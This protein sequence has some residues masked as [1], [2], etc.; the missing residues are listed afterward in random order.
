[1]FRNFRISSKSR[2]SKKKVLYVFV[3]RAAS[4]IMKNYI[5][6]YIKKSK[7]KNIKGPT[8]EKRK[9]EGGG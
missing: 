6:L 8:K 1:M 9:E 5:K 2:K 4:G 7:E 3:W